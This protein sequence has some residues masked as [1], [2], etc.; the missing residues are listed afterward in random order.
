MAAAAQE[1]FFMLM[2]T[3]AGAAQRKHKDFA[4]VS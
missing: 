4:Q 1:D 3:D 2:N